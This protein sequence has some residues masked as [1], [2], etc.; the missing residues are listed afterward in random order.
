MPFLATL[1]KLNPFL[2]THHDYYTKINTRAI[3]NHNG[4][5]P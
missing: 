1:K 4:V 2:Q 5:K 3:A